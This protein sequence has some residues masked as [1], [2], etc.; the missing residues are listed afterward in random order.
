MT[1]KL[2]PHTNRGFSDMCITLTGGVLE[3]EHVT[4]HGVFLNPEVRHA[5]LKT[6]SRTS[7]GGGLG[8]Q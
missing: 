7:N 4:E 6:Q 8:T 1:A 3:M 2:G 5:I